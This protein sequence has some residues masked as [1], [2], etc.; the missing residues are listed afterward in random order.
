MPPPTP[1]RP[2]LLVIDMQNDFCPGDGDI[3]PGALPVP[4]GRDIIPAI[5]GL[6]ARPAFVYRV[7]TRDWHP[8]G[9]VSFAENHEGK[10]A[11]T[12]SVTITHPEDVGKGGGDSGKDAP[13]PTRRAYTTRLWP[14]HCVQHTWGA[15][16]VA[17]LNLSASSAVDNANEEGRGNAPAVDLIPAKGVDL[18]LV[19]AKGVDL[20]LVSAKGVDL[21]LDKG[22]D[23][24]VE[25][26]SAFYDPLKV[27]DSGLARRLKEV[28]IKGEK[29]VEQKGEKGI[30]HV[31]VVGLAYD[32]CVR[33]TA[34]DASAEGFDVVLVRDATRAVDP[35]PDK[36]AALEKEL[37]GKGVRVRGLEDEEVR[38]W[39]G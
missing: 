31:Y 21:I 23:P 15:E 6:L 29:G 34:L 3:P 8:R 25:M 10:K 7:A 35:A 32:Y 26:Y 36:L 18:D 2:A 28:E 13:N 5:N 11:F 1:F 16:L 27:E 39:L 4:G 14:T 22:T 38:G 24:R 20:D 17:G 37:E 33:A 12:D 19:P 9:H 30:T